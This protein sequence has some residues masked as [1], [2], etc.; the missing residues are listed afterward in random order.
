MKY[1]QAPAVIDF[2]EV[3][4]KSSSVRHLDFL[5][6]LDEQ[7]FVELETDCI[8]LRQSSPLTQIVPPKSKVSFP[9]VFESNII[10]SFQR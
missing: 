5:N 3:V 9:I 2:D 4:I 7:I 1:F 6:T 8:E 10:Q